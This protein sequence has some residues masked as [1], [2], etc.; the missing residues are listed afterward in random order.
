MFHLSQSVRRREDEKI[1]LFNLR[2][3]LNSRPDRSRRAPA[4]FQ[5]VTACEPR[6]LKNIIS[7]GFPAKHES[8]EYYTN[9][10]KIF[11]KKT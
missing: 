3:R 6:S 11:F 1:T 10:N 7:D 5:R 2:S 4:N 9:V 8:V